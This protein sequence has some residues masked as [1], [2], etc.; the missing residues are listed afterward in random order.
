MTGTDN[1]VLVV[2][3]TGNQ[4]GAT[5]RR[6]LADGWRVRALTRD[7]DSA[8]AEALAAAGAQLVVGDLD[9]R[10]SLDKAVAGATGV[11]SVQGAGGL[12][13]NYSVDDEIRHGRAIA[14]AAK[15]AGVRHFVYSSVAGAERGTGIPSWEAK[16][17]IEQYLHRIDL[18]A[19]VLLPAMFM[20]NTR[21]NSPLGVQPDGTLSYFSPPDRPTQLIAVDDIG[22]F[23]GLAF[24]N[25]GEYLGKRIELAG[26]ELTFTEIA[27]AIS[28]TANRPVRYRQIS[29]T[30]FGVD[31]ES[32]RGG[33]GEGGNLWRA[34]IA[35]L[36]AIHPRLHTFD[37]WLRRNLDSFR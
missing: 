10:A 23:A 4:G 15:D 18:P 37:Q 20:E 34:D 30:A 7:P 5:A 24:G 16:W 35:A 25:P 22:V 28:V 6:L 9:D 36:R 32:T 13:P 31:T 12:V 11:F 3:A 33:S 27:T 2:G 17:Q 19:T 1:V 21:G 26:D 14:D 8:R 29:L